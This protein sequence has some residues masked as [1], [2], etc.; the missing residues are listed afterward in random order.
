VARRLVAAL[1]AGALALG[2][3][4]S[5]GSGAEGACGPIT[6]EALDRGFLVHVLEDDPGVEYTSDPPTS[7]PH[8]PSPPVGGVV[9]QPLPRPVQVGVLERGDVLIQHRPDVDASALA[10]LAAERVVIAPNP[11]L[12]A[13]V[14][15]TAWLHKRTCTEPDAEALQGFIDARVGHGPD[16]H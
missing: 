8:R 5:G 14:V 4:G 2:A 6:R 11:D 12:P 9:D 10:H 13:P 3:C 15:A 1:L 16:G 7:G